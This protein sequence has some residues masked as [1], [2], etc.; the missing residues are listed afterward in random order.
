MSAG[1]N[2]FDDPDVQAACEALFEMIADK[3]TARG[4]EMLTASLCVASADD[5]Y[6]CDYGLQTPE[7]KAALADVMGDMLGLI[8]DDLTIDADDV[9][10]AGMVH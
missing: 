6:Y 7:A 5:G 2:L 1:D 3:M 9:D 8:V 10:A 4:E